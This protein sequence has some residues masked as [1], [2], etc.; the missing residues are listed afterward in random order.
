M[1]LVMTLA[2]TVVLIGNE[3]NYLEPELLLLAHSQ[4]SA[5]NEQKAVFFS[6]TAGVSASVIAITLLLTVLDEAS[7]MVTDN[8][9]KVFTAIKT[10]WKVT[11]IKNVA[12]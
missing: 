9:D 12:R 10:I 11:I 4:L 5:C 3:S 6:C 2:V 1:V 7:R 8:D